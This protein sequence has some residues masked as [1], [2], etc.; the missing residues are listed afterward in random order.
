MRCYMLVDVHC[1]LDHTRF[2]KDRDHVIERAKK[3]GLKAILTCGIDRS[4]NRKT[5]EI[6]E[7]YDIVRPCLGIYPMDQLRKEVAEGLGHLEH[8]DFIVEQEIAFIE[9]N[10]DRLAAV[11]EIGLDYSE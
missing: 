7:K 3:A 2:D 6:A 8:E 5:L 9:K 10:K 11:A 1:H 4:T